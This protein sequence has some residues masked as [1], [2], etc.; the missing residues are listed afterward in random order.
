MMSNLYKVTVIKTRTLQVTA[1]D[2]EQAEE[3]ALALVD[4]TCDSEIDGTEV[5]FIES[6]TYTDQQEL[7]DEERRYEKKYGE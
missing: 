2:E 1:E 6:N 4:F 7:Q 5:E 3:K